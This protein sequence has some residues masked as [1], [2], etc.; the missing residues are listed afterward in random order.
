MRDVL[1]MGQQIH[2]QEAIPLERVVAAR[3]GPNLFESDHRIGVLG[4]TVRPGH[5]PHGVQR[6]SDATRA[7]SDASCARADSSCASTGSGPAPP[8]VVR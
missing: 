1:V 4:D 6:V 5:V 3:Y 7:L 2:Q 8:A